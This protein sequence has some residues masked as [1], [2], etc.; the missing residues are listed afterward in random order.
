MVTIDDKAHQLGPTLLGNW[1]AAYSPLLSWE[2]DGGPMRFQQYWNCGILQYPLA[3][4]DCDC[5]VLLEGTLPQ[6]TVDLF[7][8]ASGKTGAATTVPLH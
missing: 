4:G 1:G 5:L 7:R 3:N 2:T 8:A 6:A